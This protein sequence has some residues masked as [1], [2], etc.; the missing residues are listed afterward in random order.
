MNI[1]KN[2]KILILIILL[3]TSN[4]SIADYIEDLAKIHG[5]EFKVKMCEAAAK[6]YGNHSKWVS[7]NLQ[8][9]YSKSKPN[10]KERERLLSEF[11]EIKRM[12][13]DEDYIQ[14]KKVAELFREDGTARVEL[15][16]QLLSYSRMV[17]Y[18]IA[19]E[20]IG[21]SKTGYQSRIEED[22]KYA[23]SK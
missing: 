22:C 13:D 16:F 11:N 12:K 17:A 15:V 20:N 6:S 5:Y 2:Y 3:S 8:I 21:F 23:T 1:Q 4:V 9:I 10:S 19:V 14:R 7:D 18:S